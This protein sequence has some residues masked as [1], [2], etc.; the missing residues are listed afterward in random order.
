MKGLQK[1]SQEVM[2][3]QLFFVGKWQKFNPNKIKSMS[4][5][6]GFKEHKISNEEWRSSTSPLRLLFQS[7]TSL[8]LT[9]PS[10]MATA[11]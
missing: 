11:T 6:Y 7:S 3:V 9:C 2:P 8:L 5:A 10:K 4:E 1:W